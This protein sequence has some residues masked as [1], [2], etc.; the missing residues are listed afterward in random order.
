MRLSDGSGN[1]QS[2]SIDVA[3]GTIIPVV[4]WQKETSA[5]LMRRKTGGSWQS[6]QTVA[7]VWSP[8]GFKATPV[9]IAQG[10]DDVVVWRH[11]DP[12]FGSATGLRAR[13]Y[14]FSESIFGDEIALPST[15][16]NSTDP[17][18]AVDTYGKLHLAWA[19]SGKIYYTKFDRYYEQEEETDI[20]SY[21]ITKED[22]SSGTG[23]FA[24]HIYPSITT[25]YY[26]RPNITW[27]AFN[28]PLLIQSI[29]HRRRESSGWGSATSFTDGGEGNF[30]KPNIMS[31]PNILNNQK[32]RVTW[33]RDDNKIWLAKYN[34]SSWS[35]FSQTVNGL[36]PNLSAN[37]SATEAAKMVYRSTGSAPYTLTTTSQNLSKTT[38]QLFVHHRSGVL[39]VGKSEIAFELG[40]FEV[41]GTP[42][43]LYA[44]TDTLVA[45]HTGQW[46]E[47]FR[48]EPFTVSGETAVRYFRGF[49]VLNPDS[50][51]HI[52]PANVAIK[53]QLEVVD[54]KS[55]Q[56]LTTI[57]QHEVTNRLSAGFREIK[58]LTFH[59]PITKSIYLR[60][61]LSLPSG[62]PVSPSMVEMYYEGGGSSTPKTTP[63]PADRI[64]LL[65]LQFE[66]AQNYPNPFNPT[67]TIS[68]ALPTDSPVKLEIF[69]I[70]GRKVRTLVSG[71]L[72][73]G[74]HEIVWDG[75]NAAGTSVSSGVYLY[76]INAGRF[77]Q[78]RKMMLMR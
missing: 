35:D 36:D 13:T 63:A 65:P 2:P 10:G 74:R 24:S 32:L 49:G 53:F 56:I 9:V 64:G 44:Y 46:N 41:G 14:I 29:L 4:V 21:E 52:L 70:S 19:E 71:N 45:G 16:S 1:N 31:F 27:E 3:D 54:A 62:I 39:T 55:G 20:Y 15:N 48:T 7:D 47:M 25:D 75:R 58:A 72:P 50:L 51:G 8:S 42:V 30:Y 60:V 23:Y 69:D 43:N 76:H 12:L 78:T 22:V 18:L 61:G 33:R 37:P 11:Y 6:I 59:S 68:I 40:A 66:M 73:A 57:D 28:G 26:R 67:T 17:S 34:G 5:I 77:T 38:A